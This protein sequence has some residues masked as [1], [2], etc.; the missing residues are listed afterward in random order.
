M[1]AFVYFL[2]RRHLNYKWIRESFIVLIQAKNIIQVYRMEFRKHYK[3]VMLYQ[4]SC[5]KCRKLV[6]CSLFIATQLLL[7]SVLEINL[8]LQREECKTCNKL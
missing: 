8:R 1:S 6:A 5:Y 3:F 7:L 2:F 4:T